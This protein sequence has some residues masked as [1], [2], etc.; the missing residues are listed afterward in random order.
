[1]KVI[2]KVSNRFF[3]PGTL[4]DTNEQVGFQYGWSASD[5]TNSFTTGPEHQFV[6][7]FAALSANPISAIRQKVKQLVAAETGVSWSDILVIADIYV[8]G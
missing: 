3:S 7:S 1:M 4:I 6:L 2:A 8:E 5:G